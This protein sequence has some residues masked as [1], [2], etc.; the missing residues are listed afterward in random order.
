MRVSGWVRCDWR[1][2]RWKTRMQ[3]SMPAGWSMNHHGVAAAAATATAIVIAAA[4]VAVER[5]LF[6]T[7]CSLLLL[8]TVPR[9]ILCFSTHIRG[10]VFSSFIYFTTCL[11]WFPSLTSLSRRLSRASCPPGNI[12]KS[13]VHSWILLSI[14]AFWMFPEETTSVALISSSINSSV[15]ILPGEFEWI[16]W[17]WS[18]TSRMKVCLINGWWQTKMEFH[19]SPE[20]RCA[21]CATTRQWRSHVTYL[22]SWL[23]HSMI[24]AAV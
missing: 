6:F 23:S 8:G 2:R 15:N 11:V 21:Q 1:F 14:E 10:H 12:S 13:K 20:T 4:A 18:P 19:N 17:F 7:K 24:R 22:Q 5:L 9:K 3:R 16:N